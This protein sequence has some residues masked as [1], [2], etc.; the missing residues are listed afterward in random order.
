MFVMLPM[1]YAVRKLDGEDENIIFLLRCAYGTVQTIIISITIYCY[2]TAQKM[3]SKGKTDRIIY[4]PQTKPFPSA[5]PNAKKQYKE[6]KWGAHLIT[7]SRGLVGSTVFGA[8]ITVALHLWK[9]MVVGLAMQSVMGPFNIFENAFAKSVL[10]GNLDGRMF[11]EKTRSELSKDD[12]V[13][14]DQGNVVEKK[15]KSLEDV[16][17]DTWEDGLNAD[18]SELLSM[19]TKSNIN[20]KT[21][22]NGW[23][24]IMIMASIGVKETSS[25]MR[26]LKRLGANPSIVDN[27]GWN[28]LHW[29][30]F[31][32]SV[33]GMV[34]LVNGDE[35]NG[36]TAKGGNL[37]TVKD[38]E[39]K[40]PE[41]IARSEGNIAV[42]EIIEKR[43]EK[44]SESNETAA[45]DG[46]RKRK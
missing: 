2:L 36:M 31:H 44:E 20:F 15:K 1:M 41:T 4:V 33:D 3:A 39:G 34:A 30:A 22:E 9:G 35:F 16:L 10:M 40:T 17:L 19:L 29:A 8:C 42:A 37:H 11:E 45:Q 24:P 28:A 21:K 27:E 13:I 14:D 38:K 26:Q 25:A 23:T 6:V 43:V 5:D 7:V 32:G 12:E 18:I 46:L